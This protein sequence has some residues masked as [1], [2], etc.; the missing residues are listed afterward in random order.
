M[1]ISANRASSGTRITF[2]AMRVT[3]ARRV[4]ITAVPVMTRW[5][6]TPVMRTET[7][8][9]WKDGG[10]TTALT[11]SATCVFSFV[12]VW[13]LFGPSGQHVWTEKKSFL[14]TLYLYVSEYDGVFGVGTWAAG[15]HPPYLVLMSVCVPDGGWA[16]SPKL[17]HFFCSAEQRN[18]T[19]HA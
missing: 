8:N 6:I 12:C 19:I 9:A 16:A 11:V 17:L 10:E 14:I 15:K 7:R 3:T 1:F 2:S 4:P 13:C 5:D 18:S